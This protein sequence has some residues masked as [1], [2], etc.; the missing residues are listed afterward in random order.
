[1]KLYFPAL[2]VRTRDCQQVSEQFVGENL[3]HDRLECEQAIEALSRDEEK[4]EIYR[5][6]IASQLSCEFT[7]TTEMRTL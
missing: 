2:V 4:I 3:H 7:I 6:I 1:M 5:R